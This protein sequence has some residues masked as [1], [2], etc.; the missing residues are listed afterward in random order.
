MLD[1]MCVLGLIAGGV[2][3]VASPVPDD[4]GW[5]AWQGGVARLGVTFSARELGGF[6]MA[7]GQGGG[8]S[9]SDY[10]DDGDV[11]LFAPSREGVP[12][13]V[14]RNRGD[15]T[16]DEVGAAIGL[17]DLEAARNALWFDAD[18]DGR[19]DLVVA[20][21]RYQA[22]GVT[23]S[24]TLRLW[25]Q[26]PDGTFVEATGTG[27]E[28]VPLLRVGT[29]AGGLAAG[30][31]TGNG[32]LDLVFA[33]WDEGAWIFE[34]RSTPGAPLFADIRASA[35]LAGVQRTYWQPVIL[36]LNDDGLEDVF[37]AH[38]F[39]PN[40]ALINDGGWGTGAGGFTDQGAPLGLNT[41]MNEMG[42][43]VGDC[44]A[45]G[46]FD[47]YVT[48]LTRQIF[49]LFQY[50]VLFVDEG[51][52]F[53]ER[54]LEHPV[55]RGG[56][57]WGTTFLDYDLDGRLDLAEVNSLESPAGFADVPWKLWKNTGRLRG[58]A[59][60][61][62]RQHGAGLAF[63]DAGSALAAAD[64][65]RDGDADLVATVLSD[66]TQPGA[67]R[68]MTNTASTIHPDRDWVIV[69]PRMPGTPNARAIGAVVR[70]TERGWTQS[71]KITAGVSFLSQEPAEAHV[72][73]GARLSADGLIDRVT[74][75]WPDG[76]SS[77]WTQV[78]AG[79]V[80]TLNRP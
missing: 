44:D 75:K 51:A 66:A 15:G 67:L 40:P 4:G 79:G 8:V 77:V 26:Q 19:Q 74:I 20:Q 29:H 60:F 1:S 5:R 48:N 31:L 70:V 10:D 35:G 65:D 43:A 32:R 13:R 54:A 56:F 46:D 69:R 47:L 2:A 61:V 23:L 14:Y 80:V 25:L 21:D 49:T 12:N 57:G 18:G 42:V 11:D 3:Q 53:V 55:W 9:L 17:D 7:L 62:A 59:A 34:N 50:C 71:R 33:T 41:A 6:S 28:G 64:L 38:D 16:F 68:V 76:T 73:F 72:A 63:L 22:P 24:A 30:D 39:G 78:P 52:G 36:D 58:P 27:L 37:L 45:D